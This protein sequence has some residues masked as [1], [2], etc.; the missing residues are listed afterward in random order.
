MRAFKSTLFRLA[1][2]LLIA[3]SPSAFAGYVVDA[4]ITAVRAA[5]YNIYYIFVSTDIV[6]DAASCS[7]TGPQRVFVFDP[8]TAA[9][10]AMLNTVLLAKVQSSPVTVIGRAQAGTGFTGSAAC[11]NAPGSTATNG[12]ETISWLEAR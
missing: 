3:A 2:S 5:E 7:G 1:A 9:G 12:V 6:R 8:S 11:N 4:T 10:K